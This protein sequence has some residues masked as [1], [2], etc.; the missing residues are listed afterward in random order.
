MGAVLDKGVQFPERSLVQQ[1]I[2][3]FTGSQTSL[4]MLCIDPFLS[5]TQARSGFVFT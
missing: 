1:E 2:D 4:F 3:P 5:P